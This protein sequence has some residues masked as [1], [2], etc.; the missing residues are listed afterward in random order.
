MGYTPA[1]TRREELQ[2]EHSV[3]RELLARY[4]EHRDKALRDLADAQ[5]RAERYEKAVVGLEAVLPDEDHH[6]ES[7]KDEPPESAPSRM[8]VST[9]G[10]SPQSRGPRGE[11]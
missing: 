9:N 3:E 10:A 11:A 4:R 2:D 7:P 6:D 8:S 5:A 1:M